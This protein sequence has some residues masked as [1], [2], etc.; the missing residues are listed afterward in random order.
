MLLGEGGGELLD[1][2]DIGE[3]RD[4]LGGTAAGGDL[5][6][7]RLGALLA[8]ARH[9]DVRARVAEHLGRLEADPVLEPVT[10]ATLPERSSSHPTLMPWRAVRA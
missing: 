4:H 3:V 1:G 9:N 2:V 5:G 7:S 10:M 6:E 8:A